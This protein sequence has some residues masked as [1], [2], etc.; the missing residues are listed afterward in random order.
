MPNIPRGLRTLHRAVVLAS[1][2][3]TERSRHREPAV[4]EGRVPL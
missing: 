1:R 3:V 2:E 4:I